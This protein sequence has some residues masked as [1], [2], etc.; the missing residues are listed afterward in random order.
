M[1]LQDINA[2]EDFDKNFQFL[3]RDKIRRRKTHRLSQECFIKLW[4]TSNSLDEFMVKISKINN[5]LEKVKKSVYWDFGS[6][7]VVAVLKQRGEKYIPHTQVDVHQEL[8]TYETIDYLT[9]KESQYMWQYYNPSLSS[10]YR[11]Y[12]SRA[13]R[14]RNKGVP[15]KKLEWF[16]SPPMPEYPATDWKA[17][18]KIAEESA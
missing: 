4:Q 12:L 15:M 9:G 11:G 14:Y 17:L 5:M 3:G 13:T 8:C 7:A 6:Y 1:K 10:F 16:D 2:A 18:A